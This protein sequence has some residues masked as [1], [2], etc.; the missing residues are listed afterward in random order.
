MGLEA[1]DKGYVFAS[2]V[3]LSD[4]MSGTLEYQGTN[5]PVETLVKEL[6]GF[7]PASKRATLKVDSFVPRTGFEFDIIKRY[8]ENTVLTFKVQFGGSGLVM[9]A[10]GWVDPPSISFST[11][12]STKLS[13]GATIEAKAFTGQVL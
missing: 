3:L 4:A 8:L 9:E 11:T 1:F 6:A 10:D 13:F 5:T 7:T 12:D 2:G